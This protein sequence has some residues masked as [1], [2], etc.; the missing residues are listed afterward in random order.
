MARSENGSS[1]RC[2]NVSGSLRQTRKPAISP[3]ASCSTKCERQPKELCSTPPIIGAP[4][5]ASDMIAPIKA[6]SFP[7]RA[8][9]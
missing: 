1:R 7:A 4:T 2:R 3:N 8:P 9:E 6:S 5:G